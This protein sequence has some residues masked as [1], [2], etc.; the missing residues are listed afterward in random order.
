MPEGESHRGRSLQRKYAGVNDDQPGGSISNGDD[1]ARDRRSA[2]RQRGYEREHH[3]PPCAGRG[4]GEQRERRGEGKAP[5]RLRPQRDRRH[6]LLVLG[7][8]R[9]LPHEQHAQPAVGQAESQPEDGC[10]AGEQAKA[11]RPEAAR[12]REDRERGGDGDQCLAG[13]DHH[14]AGPRSA[15]DPAVRALGRVA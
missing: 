3:Q 2:E 15:G 14:C 8:R 12:D 13:A 1:L 7:P 10:P 5:G 6:P 4:R 11:P 9:Q